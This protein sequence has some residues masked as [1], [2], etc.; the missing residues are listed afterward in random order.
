MFLVKIYL[1]LIFICQINVGRILLWELKKV[2]LLDKINNLKTPD[3]EDPKT[4]SAIEIKKN[5]DNIDLLNKL[6]TLHGDD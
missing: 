6:T 1:F 2:P 4:F 3:S 5:P